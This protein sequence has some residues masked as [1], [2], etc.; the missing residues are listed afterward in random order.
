[1]SEVYSTIVQNLLVPIYDLI[2]KTSRYKCG[3]ILEKTQ[4]LSRE[5]I[6]FL[7][8]KN[9]QALMTHAYA[10]VPYYHRIFKERGLTPDDIKTVQD[11]KKLPVLTKDVIRK[12]FVDLVSKDFSRNQ[13]IPYSTGGTG[14]PLEF[15]ITT[16]K[17]SWEVA[18]E[19]RAYRW[20]GCQLGDRCFMF[21]GAHRD[22]GSSSLSFSYY[23]KKTATLLQRTV[24]V[25]PFVLSDEVLSK[26]ASMLR[27][28]NPEVIKGYAMPI[29]MAAKYLMEKG[30]DDVRPRTVITSAET[31]FDSMRKTIERAFSCPVFDYYGSR[32][33]SPIAAECEEHLYHIAAE[34]V[35]V[36]FVRDGENVSPGEDGMILLTS[37]RNYGMPFIRYEIG[38]VGEPS[39]EV[40]SCGRGLPLIK[41]IG[42]LAS[43]LLSARDK[44]T[45][46]IV[47]VSG[48]IDYFMTHL[49]SP[50]ASF[51]II[52]E[53]LD[54]VIIKIVKGRSCS[55]QDTDLLV[56]ELRN[57]L[58][59]DVKIEV[60]FIDTLPPLPSGKR[61]PVISKINAFEDL[62]SKQ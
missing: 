52:Q 59:S 17:I 37:L 27:K 6:D 22:L 47:P 18:A 32:E 61:S 30:I 1:V 51:R 45:G 58:G 50:P 12:N 39:N 42:G 48:H 19:Y 25:D 28:F 43:Q 24:V 5:E 38:D 21:W 57:F 40:C 54:H 46:R 29:Y 53:S 35:V 20:A 49:K 31:L 60:Q 3:R 15:F 23:A 36:E 56:R 62:S 10:T 9:L 41:S 16:D 55:N 33:V 13:L 4:Y 14:S 8:S 2:R 7:Q 26:F 34:N 44:S 11:L